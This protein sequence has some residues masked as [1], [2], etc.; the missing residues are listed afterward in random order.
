MCIVYVCIACVNIY[1][2]NS[3]TADVNVTKIAG[4]VRARIL[5]DR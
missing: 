1:I 5:M 3:L 4:Y 2:G